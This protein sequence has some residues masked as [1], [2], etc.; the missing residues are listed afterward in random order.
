MLNVA[1]ENRDVLFLELV[2]VVSVSED[3]AVHAVDEHASRYLR[4]RRVA[5]NHRAHNQH[6]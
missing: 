2:D 5:L 6:E 1:G 4:V 3:I